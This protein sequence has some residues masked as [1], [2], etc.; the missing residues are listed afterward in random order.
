MLYWMHGDRGRRRKA[1]V[2]ARHQ[3]AAL[4]AGRRYGALVHVARGRCPVV[5]VARFH[6]Q[7]VLGQER[8]EVAILQIKYVGGRQG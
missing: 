6:R 8:V 3:R 2:D 1:T 7:T 4:M 5:L